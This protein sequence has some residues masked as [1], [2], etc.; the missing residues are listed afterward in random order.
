MLKLEGDAVEKSKKPN[1]IA[2]LLKPTTD[3]VSSVR[4][5]I[6]VLACLLIVFQAF[7]VIEPSLEMKF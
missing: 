5:R 4:S 7:L 6:F 2:K 1:D 3:K